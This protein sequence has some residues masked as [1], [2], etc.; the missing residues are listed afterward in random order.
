MGGGGVIVEII[1]CRSPTHPTVA[2]QF[3]VAT[4]ALL[5]PLRIELCDVASALR[6]LISANHNG[7][8]FSPPHP[9][10]ST[11]TV[12]ANPSQQQST[13]NSTVVS[14]ITA[15]AAAAVAAI[16][17]S[18]STALSLT[19]RT[20]IP[21]PTR[22]GGSASAPEAIATPAPPRNDCV[23]VEPWA[24]GLPG[25]SLA[26]TTPNL[27]ARST[28]CNGEARVLGVQARRLSRRRSAVATY[29]GASAEISGGPQPSGG[30]SG[31]SEGPEA[32]LMRAGQ[33]S[34]SCLFS[35]PALNQQVAAQ[36]NAGRASNGVPGL[37]ACGERRR[38]SAA[39]RWSTARFTWPAEQAEADSAADPA[40]AVE[41][42]ESSKRSADGG[43]RRTVFAAGGGFTAEGRDTEPGPR[44]RS[45]ES[46]LSR[47]AGGGG[48]SQQSVPVASRTRKSG[49][50]GR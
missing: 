36:Q 21:V 48:G 1:Q 39:T 37:I 41:T 32:A 19:P 35:H 17:A 29:A 16:G 20:Q 47:G 44:A 31:N 33:A 10:A 6:L 4:R 45:E 15:A 9:S 23:L 24:A 26:D 5:E 25:P 34:H 50:V 12:A 3:E 49:G 38:S 18:P 42:L 43:G 14:A 8:V 7:H 11:A 13:P 27:P 46:G 28:V 2:A 40:E 22:G 30:S